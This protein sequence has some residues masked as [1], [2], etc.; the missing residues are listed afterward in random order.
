MFMYVYTHRT[1]T[2]K[3]KILS[4]GQKVPSCPF[5]ISIIPGSDITGIQTSVKC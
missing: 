3:D 1:I 5:P 2:D 4:L